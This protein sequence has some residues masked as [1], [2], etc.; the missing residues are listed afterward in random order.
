MV[1]TLPE[2]HRNQSAFG[3]GDHDLFQDTVSNYPEV[4]DLR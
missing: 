3:A 1:L 2:L 4:N